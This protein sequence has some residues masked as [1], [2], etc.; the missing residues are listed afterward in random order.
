MMSIIK[1]SAIAWISIPL[2]VKSCDAPDEVALGVLARE[3]VALT[4]T[5]NEIITGQPVPEGHAVS[6]GTILVQLDDRLARANL[7]IALARRAQA[8][9]DLD[10]MQGGERAEEIAIAEARVEGARAV[11]R[12]ADTTL[13]RSRRLFESDII[14]QARL[15]QDIARRDSALAD[16]TRAEQ[17][18]IEIRAGAREEDIRIA[19]AKLRAAD[20]RVLAER[21]RLE[22]LTIRASRAGTLD[23]LPW[24]LGERVPLGSPVAVILTGDRPFARVYVPEPALARLNIG[25]RVQIALDGV[26]APLE[27]SV[28]WI[29]AEPAFTPYYALNQEQRSRLVF[30][31]EIDLPPD[32]GALPVGLPVTVYIP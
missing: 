16:M 32:A 29:S 6:E 18:L 21:T 22:D 5:A 4:A 7:E 12:E 10:R 14:T 30:L 2:L 28:R 11:Y 27:G 31:T 17:A 13:E 8:Q 15:D 9:A 24:N 1:A 26:A 3:R 19:E 20:A 23:N 25:D